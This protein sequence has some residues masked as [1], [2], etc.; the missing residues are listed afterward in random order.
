[1][2]TKEKKVNPPR[3]RNRRNTE[4]TH[5]KRR[6]LVTG[7]PGFIGKCLVRKLLKAEP[8][9]EFYLL[10]QEKFLDDA[11]KYIRGIRRQHREKI[12]LLK[13]DI[14]ETDLGL[15]ADELQRIRR[16][17]TDIYHL[18]AVSYLGITKARMWRVNVQ[19]TLNMLALANEV[20]H[21][22]RFN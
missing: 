7:Y 20:E 19:G 17:V 13:G 15:A 3:N 9:S 18:A 11:H 8:D 5:P 6:V 1:M 4:K 12:H 2:S 10:V 21:L 22:K 14:A 16:K